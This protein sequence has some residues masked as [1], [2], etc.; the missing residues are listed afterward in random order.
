[1][2]PVWYTLRETNCIILDYV[3]KI[4]LHIFACINHLKFNPTQISAMTQW[5][6]FMPRITAWK[7]KCISIVIARQVH[8][9]IT[10][11]ITFHHSELTIHFFEPLG[12]LVR[13]TSKQ[14]NTRYDKCVILV[15]AD[16]LHLRTVNWPSSCT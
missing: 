3:R 11:Q 12:F 1:M 9:E 2:K 6:L 13:K 5:Y 7:H 15:T 14:H 16:K 8:F 4:I 10:F